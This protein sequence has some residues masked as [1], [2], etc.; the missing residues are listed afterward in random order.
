MEGRHDNDGLDAISGDVVGCRRCPRLVRW[1][2]RVAREKKR[3]FADEAY[4]GRPVPAFGD[5]QARLFVI[6][7]APAAHGGNRTGRMFTGDRSG[8]WLYRALHRAG[9]ANQATAVSRGDG[10]VL[11]DCIITAAVRCV[12]PG[13]LPTRSEFARC[14][15]FLERE[16][17]LLTN[18]K[19]VV[20]L[21]KAAMDAFLR[22]WRAIGR[23]I[24]KP[25][26]TFRHGQS[27]R[28]PAMTLLAS[29]HP[30]QRNT[31]TGLLR[32]DMFDAIFRT[33][34]EILQRG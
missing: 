26:P 3:A 7:L 27:W 23:D 2:E 20:P 16:L 19:V 10:L 4:W 15:P 1:R 25:R 32:E 31:S 21:G 9:F 24:P 28:L 29:Y 30:S 13:N 18:L 11:H 34:Q 33:A 14:Q 5:S 12:P 17:R 6:G 22:A 8:A